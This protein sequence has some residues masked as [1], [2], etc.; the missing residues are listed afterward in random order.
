MI[1]LQTPPRS[2]VL[3]RTI[4]FQP[5]SPP[6]SNPFALIGSLLFFVDVAHD[7][8]LV[9]LR[10]FHNHWLDPERIEL[11]PSRCKRDVLPLSLRAQKCRPLRDSNPHLSPFAEE[12]PSIRRSGH[13]GPSEI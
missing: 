4:Y 1:H 13:G 12:H 11:S 8:I 2:A 6:L 3:T 7:R 5:L 10:E 9:Q